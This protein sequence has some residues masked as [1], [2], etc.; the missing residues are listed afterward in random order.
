MQLKIS[1]NTPQAPHTKLALPAVVDRPSLPPLKDN[2]G[3]PPSNLAN[4]FSWASD[5]FLVAPLTKVN[6]LRTSLD[7]YLKSE[8]TK[9]AAAVRNDIGQL[10]ELDTTTHNTLTNYD[11][12]LTLIDKLHTDARTDLGRLKTQTT[13]KTQLSLVDLK[14]KGI[15][16]NRT[17]KLKSMQPRTQLKSAA[18][19]AAVVFD[20]GAKLCI[21]EMGQRGYR[22]REGCDLRAR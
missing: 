12:D 20:I 8:N 2:S 15:Q 17:Q 19:A 4:C 21:G 11:Q 9:C 22:D 13:L 5:T 18:S 16:K 10:R 7:G 14:S 3:R 6:T 1:P